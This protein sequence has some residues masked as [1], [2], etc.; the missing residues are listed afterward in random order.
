RAATAI[1]DEPLVWA[2][3]TRHLPLYWFP[4]DCPRGTFWAG[5]ATTDR[6]VEHFVGGRLARAPLERGGH[7]L[8]LPG[9]LGD[10]VEADDA[11]RVLGMRHE[12]DGRRTAQAPHLLRIDHLERV[13]E[14]AAGLA[15]HLAEHERR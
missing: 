13:A 6:D 1:A 15:F 4:R 9:T 11:V 3:G 5:P 14:A 2:I 10:D 7:A 8:E 12:P